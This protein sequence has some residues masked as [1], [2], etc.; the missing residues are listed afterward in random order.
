MQNYISTF[1]DVKGYGLAYLQKESTSNYDFYT[2]PRYNSYLS[3]S[4]NTLCL[5]I[6]T[7]ANN[8]S[9]NAKSPIYII[10]NENFKG[11]EKRF[12]DYPQFQFKYYVELEQKIEEAIIKLLSLAEDKYLMIPSEIK[13]LLPNSLIETSNHKLFSLLPFVQLVNPRRMQI[14]KGE[15]RIIMEI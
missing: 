3:H 5:N 9:N 10:G 1:V 4:F 8:F 6:C 15:W 12:R 7:I 11:Y 13:E 14:R 2:I